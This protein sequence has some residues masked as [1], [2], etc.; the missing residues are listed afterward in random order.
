MAEPRLSVFM[1]MNNQDPPFLSSILRPK[2]GAS[3][4]RL[5]WECLNRVE[6]LTTLAK[7]HQDLFKDDRLRTGFL[8]ILEDAH[9]LL[10]YALDDVDYPDDSQD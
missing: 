2:D 1:N 7:G 9:W 10:G 3:N 4:D 8:L 5:L 6:F